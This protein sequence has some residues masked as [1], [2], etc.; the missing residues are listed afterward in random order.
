M[1]L[2]SFRALALS[3]GRD[4]N[5]GCALLLVI[6]KRVRSLGQALFDNRPH[7]VG[8]GCLTPL[9]TAGEYAQRRRKL[10]DLMQPN[11][12][13]IFA[14]NTLQ[15]ASPSV[16]YPF[17]Q[18]PNFQYL[19]GFLEP[20][21]CLLLRKTADGSA[22][23]TTLVVPEKDDLAE[24]WEGERTGSEQAREV[25]GIDDVRS[26]ASLRE[27]VTRLVDSVAT[28]YADTSPQ[29][30]MRQ[31]PFF[32]QELAKLVHPKLASV[33]ASHL[34]M[35][36]REIKSEAEIDCLRVAAEASSEAYN[37]AYGQNFSAEA[38]LQSYLGFMFKQ[39]GCES[40]SYYPVVAGGSH[41]LT[42][43]YVRND[44]LLSPGDLV[45]VDAAG[46]YGGYCADISRTWPVN[47]KFTQPQ[48]DLY[49]AVLET[50]KQC[51]QQCTVESGMSLY[52][53]HVYSEAKL[54]ENLANMGLKLSANDLRVVYP[55]MIGH[56]LGLDVHDISLPNSATQRLR[57]NQVI[58]IEPGV[59]VPFSD[60]F[61]QHFQGIGI[62][63]EDNIVIGTQA[64][65]N[66]TESCLKE[67]A[68]VQR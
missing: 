67:V 36:L 46:R 17:R 39:H 18:D 38:Q 34:A 12:L 30:T 32:S 57:A 27:T 6:M 51:I 64:Y 60:K 31:V 33:P 3:V 37:A 9:V 55:H 40:D 29:V 61:P 5:P 56:Q 21:A 63:I 62:R 35:T 42:I 24:K 26:N 54:R 47:G 7:L 49:E 68:D 10:M 53:L 1:P 19:T 20:Q 43:H 41:A 25:F 11:S 28:V 50:E 14:G 45:L 44:D 8:K 65:E 52:D 23:E 66:L 16:F 4:A 2:L 13:A 59:Y 58:T 22:D 15:Y 48:R